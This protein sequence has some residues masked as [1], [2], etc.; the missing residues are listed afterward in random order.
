M[1]HLRLLKVDWFETHLIYIIYSFY[2]LNFYLTSSAWEDRHDWPEASLHRRL[3]KFRVNRNT[4][5]ECCSLC[6]NMAAVM[7][8]E[9]IFPNLMELNLSLI[10]LEWNHHRLLGGKIKREEKENRKKDRWMEK[11]KIKPHLICNYSQAGVKYERTET[12]EIMCSVGRSCFAEAFNLFLFKEV[13]LWQT[14]LK[15]KTRLNSFH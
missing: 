5:P 3:V 12:P 9:I 1:V 11:K 2:L 7:S 13:F 4:R 10:T 8:R 15:N 6:L 14:T